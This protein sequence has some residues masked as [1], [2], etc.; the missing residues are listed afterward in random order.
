MRI[1]EILNEIKEKKLSKKTIAMP[2]HTD[3]SEQ[4]SVYN[5]LSPTEREQLGTENYIPYEDW[6]RFRQYM[7]NK[8]TMLNPA[9]NPSLT[10]YTPGETLNLFNN[11]IIHKWHTRVATHLVPPEYDTVA[12]VPCAKTKPWA[13]C[14]TGNYG[15]YNKLRE[16]HGNIYWVTVSEPLGIVPQDEWGSFPQYDNPGLFKDAPTRSDMHSSDWLRLYP[17][18][19]RKDTYLEKSPG[20][21]KTPFDVAAYEK[22]INILS[23]IIRNFVATNRKN[24]PELGFISF[25]EDVPYNIKRKKVGSHSHMISMAG[26]VEPESRYLKRGA[27]REAPYKYIKN[28]LVNREKSKQ[29]KYIGVN[30]ENN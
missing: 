28:I 10:A 23:S 21:L 25:V 6:P 26:A 27:A 20:Y 24:R 16:E 22:A 8:S 13:G 19:A 11:P 29:N 9:L 4:Q 15:S 5:K 18:E 17:P 30:D 14:T 7:V 1:H 2:Q 12:F 3:Q